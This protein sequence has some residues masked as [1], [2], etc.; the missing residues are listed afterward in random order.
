MQINRIKDNLLLISLKI[1]NNNP[2]IHPNRVFRA[3]KKN[4]FKVNSK[5]SI[6]NMSSSSNHL[7]QLNHNLFLN[8]S[9]II[10][11][12]Y[13]NNQAKWLQFKFKN[14]CTWIKWIILISNNKMVTFNNNLN[15]T[16]KL[17]C[18]CKQAVTFP[19][20]NSKLLILLILK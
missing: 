1:C 11:N 5:C 15:C 17:R 10:S 16:N 7:S 9:P 4:I 6:N 20:N 2:H 12:I 19:T 14:K 3:L 8:N 13:N 18:I